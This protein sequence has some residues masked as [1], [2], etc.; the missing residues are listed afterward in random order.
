MQ[1][2]FL[3]LKCL[4]KIFKYFEFQFCSQRLNKNQSSMSNINIW[5]SDQIMYTLLS[6]VLI[7]NNNLISL[8]A[9]LSYSCTIFRIFSEHPSNAEKFLYAHKRSWGYSNGKEGN[10]LHRRNIFCRERCISFDLLRAGQI[11]WVDYEFYCLEA[12]EVVRA[13]VEEIDGLH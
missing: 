13:Y 9:P 2:F 5:F 11:K 3:W 10:V 4:P 1:V 12:N 6:R 7:K 8:L